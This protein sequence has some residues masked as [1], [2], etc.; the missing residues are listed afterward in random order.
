MPLTLFTFPS[1]GRIFGAH[2]SFSAGSNASY[3]GSVSSLY[4]QL[5]LAVSGI[6]LVPIELS[7]CTISQNANGDGDPSFP[8]AGLPVA[9]GEMIQIDVNNG[10]GLVGSGGPSTGGLIRASATVLYSIP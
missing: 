6:V 3:S 7:I 4:S 5:L 8:E 9:K 10:V 2:L 1:A